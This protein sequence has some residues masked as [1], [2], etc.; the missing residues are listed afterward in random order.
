MTEITVRTEQKRVLVDITDRV[1]SAI[2]DSGGE[3][4]VYM[5][6][7]PHTTAGVAINE[8]ADPSVARDIGM[9]FDRLAPDD[10]PYEHAEGNS[11]AHVMSCIAGSSVLVGWSDGAVELGTWQAIF[12]CE[13]DGPRTRRAWVRRL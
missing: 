3:E 2:R 13:F 5:V 9:V 10:L 12:F 7:V 6:Y 1:S 11:P 8:G 4:G